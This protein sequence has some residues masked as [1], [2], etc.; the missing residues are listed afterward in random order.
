MV[1]RT[2]LN[3]YLSAYGPRARPATEIVPQGGGAAIRAV[4]AGLALP[5]QGR[6]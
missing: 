5:S 6:S 3:H 2:E 1:S 4:R